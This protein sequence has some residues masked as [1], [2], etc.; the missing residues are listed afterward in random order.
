M[1]EVELNRDE[2]FT[3]LVGLLGLVQSMQWVVNWIPEKA[4]IW[5]HE[6]ITWYWK[7]TKNIRAWAIFAD[8]QVILDTATQNIWTLQVIINYSIFWQKA[9]HYILYQFW[10]TMTL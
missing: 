9:D 5:V 7:L 6:M 10:L 4:S 2:L 8:P 1:I 3:G